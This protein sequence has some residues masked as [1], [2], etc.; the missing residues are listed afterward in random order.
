MSYPNLFKLSSARQLIFGMLFIAVCGCDD[1]KPL[2]K[3]EITPEAAEINVKS[4]SFD[5]DLF[6]CDF[7]QS[8]QCT[9]RLRSAYGTFF[10]GF[11]ED[12]LRLAACASDSVDRLLSVFVH[13]PQIAQTHEAVMAAFPIEKRESLTNSFAEVVRR[14]H[15]F[16]PQ[17]PIPEIIYYC[18]AWNRSIA[19]TDSIIGIALDCYL[20][21]NHEITQKLSPDI[22]PGYVKENMDERYII[23]DAVKG[24]SAW[25]ARSIYQQKDLLSELLFYGKIMYVAEALAPDLAD[26]TLMNWNTRQWQWALAGEENVWKTLANEKTMYQSKP[27]EINKWFADGPFTSVTGIP[28]QSAPQLGV[29]M[30]WN[31]IRSYMKKYPD[32]SLEALLQE[33]DNQRLLSAYVPGKR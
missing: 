4:S 19:T 10:C 23:A 5:I 15:H 22:F 16:F 27:F 24:F 9:A 14:W 7:S 26:S 8:Q 25:N 28:Q 20:G 29:W 1:E 3:I 17:K 31:I 6:A 13:D 32:T 11:V 12:D 18:S 21:A 30:G 33:T 2:K